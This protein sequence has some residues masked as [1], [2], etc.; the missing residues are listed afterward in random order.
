MKKQFLLS[1]F[2]ALAAASAATAAEM[3]EKP[4]GERFAVA[5]RELVDATFSARVVKG[6]SL[7][8]YPAYSNLMTLASCVHH[9]LPAGTRFP[10][11]GFQFF[12]S[13]GKRLKTAW[14]TQGSVWIWSSEPRAYRHSAYVPE[15]ATAAQLCVLRMEKTNEVEVADVKIRRLDG[16]AQPTRNVNPDFDYGLFN[17][18]GYS[19]MGSARA[20]VDADGRAWFDLLQGS[21]YP[22]AVPVN[23]GEELEIRFRGRS[24]TWLHWY[25]CFYSNYAD[26]GDLHKNKKFYVLDV[27]NKKHQGVRVETLQVPPDAT[28]MRVYFQP[29]GEI[30]D[31]RIVP[32]GKEAK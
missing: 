22:D 31:L 10:Q 2:A 26:V 13:D 11:A 20:R 25:V 27:N 6:A 3:F 32:H 28:W 17:T 30:H 24:P 21:C 5:A 9:A 8:A 1:A 4:V 19:F 23:G 12:G 18:S 14:L 15:G 16:F 7:E 29:V